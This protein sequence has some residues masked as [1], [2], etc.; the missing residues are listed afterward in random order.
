MIYRNEVI[1]IYHA[2]R[3]L[4]RP[5]SLNLGA[6][7]LTSNSDGYTVWNLVCITHAM[8]SPPPLQVSFENSGLV[9]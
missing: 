5:E 6:A 3:T 8:N 9:H 4:S 2:G 7:T 1:Q